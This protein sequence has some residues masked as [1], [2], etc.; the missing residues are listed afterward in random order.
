VVEVSTGSHLRA[1]RPTDYFG[2]AR[3]PIFDLVG[4]IQEDVRKAI[5]TLSDED[6]LGQD[7]KEL[8]RRLFIEHRLDTPV[9]VFSDR[10]N[11][12]PREYDEH[13]SRKEAREEAARDGLGVLAE[14]LYPD[15]NNREVI[16]AGEATVSA[17]TR[18]HVETTVS[19]PCLGT[20]E[21]T[22]MLSASRGS[23]PLI[24]SI[25]GGRLQFL[26]DVTSAGD[27]EKDPEWI[28][29]KIDAR[30]E[31]IV[32][33]WQE[34]FEALAP[35]VASA[36]KQLRASI[37]AMVRDVI[38]KKVVLRGVTDRLEVQLAVP[39]FR[40]W[41]LYLAN[42]NGVFLAGF[43]AALALAAALSVLTLATGFSEGLSVAT[44][45]AVAG[46]VLSTAL[47]AIVRAAPGSRVARFAVR[48]ARPV[49]IHL[50][51]WLVGSIVADFV[52]GAVTVLLAKVL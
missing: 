37:A 44:M 15:F 16:V 5:A 9:L 30:V 10:T 36:N 32:A 7:P 41:R 43:G 46:I 47:A 27:S 6:L 38:T 2:L 28:A 35:L 42:A 45:V 3:R 14:L 24:G 50:F 4:R 19:I 11:S 17:P 22:R 33:P 52:I 8:G 31:A 48:R 12:P 40:R 49:L 20:P 21:L 39:R 25:K 26:V 1:S 29:R 18:W 51:D 34:Q 13:L 23:L